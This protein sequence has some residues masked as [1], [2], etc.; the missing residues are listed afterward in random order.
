MKAFL[1]G[2]AVRDSLMGLPVNDRDWV[3]VGCTDPQ[4]MV[5]MGFEQ[6]GQ[7]FPVFLHPETRE[8]WALAR[9]ERKTGVGYGGFAVDTSNVTLEEDLARR[10][11]TI[12]AVAFDVEN[13]QHID[14]FGGMEDIKNK[15]LRHVSD[16]F[17]EDPLRVV[18]LARFY[19][20]YT[21]FSVALETFDM[22]SRVVL[23]GEMD[24]LPDERFVKEFEKVVNDEG[25]DFG[26]FVEMLH[27][28]GVFQHVK[29]FKKTFTHRLLV[30]VRTMGEHV[31]AMKDAG[32]GG[33]TAAVL[34]AAFSAATNDG[35]A[36]L[37]FGSEVRDA[38]EAL[39][40]FTA[41]DSVH[42]T[43]N[44]V[45]NTLKKVRSTRGLSA[46]ADRALTVMY[47][48]DR[49]HG[50]KMTFRARAWRKFAEATASVDVQPLVAQFSGKELGDQLHTAMVAAVEKV[51]K[52]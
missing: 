38:F 50:W 28:M 37:R 7:S 15:V 45:V 22:A 10:D 26:R 47:A 42:A 16:A 41:A 34:V 51:L 2:G 13:N 39:K 35:G 40:A 20:R 5:D 6:V 21:D 27:M 12:N 4:I 36:L 44:D 29:F 8:E 30:H 3:V 32:L 19:A 43:A 11:L 24:S 49:A 18:R 17:A 48:L 31:A 23:S 52:G 1:V 9:T 14:P 46:H 25:S 33:D